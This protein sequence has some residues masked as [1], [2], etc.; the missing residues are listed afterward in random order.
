MSTEF[1]IEALQEAV[2]RHGSPEIFNPDEGSQ[3]TVEAFTRV[4]AQKGR[5]SEHGP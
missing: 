5:A 4:L 3:F 1:C 2:R